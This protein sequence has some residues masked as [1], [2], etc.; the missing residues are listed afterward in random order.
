MFSEFTFRG[1]G[2][3]A[4]KDQRFTFILDVELWT[5]SLTGFV[6]AYLVFRVKICS[7]GAEIDNTMN[8][9]YKEVELD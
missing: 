3:S 4:Q 9:T 7:Q 1:E 5:Q 2:G 8:H 6:H